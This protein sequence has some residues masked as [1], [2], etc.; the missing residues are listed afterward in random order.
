MKAIFGLG[1]PEARYRRTRHNLGFMA[2]D[3]YLEQLRPQASLRGLLT[4]ARL[5]GRRVNRALVYRARDD[6]LLVKPLTYMNRSGL[7]V[8]EI[9]A[10]FKLKLE[11]CLIV[12][13]DFDIPW[14]RLRARARGGSGGH[15]GLQSIIEELGTEEV[16]RLRIGIGSRGFQGD[17]TAYVLGRFTPEELKGLGAVLARA[18]AALDLFYKKGIEEM[19]NEV[20]RGGQLDKATTDYYNGIDVG[21]DQGGGG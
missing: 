6:R 4:K 18:V 15:K 11:D 21:R 14:G 5:R 1:N 8:R 3:R 19:M 7:A 17:L 12:Y 10:R 16:P 13:D 20:N 2:I 9:V